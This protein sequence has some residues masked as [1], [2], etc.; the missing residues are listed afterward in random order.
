MKL[1]QHKK[2]EYVLLI[3]F[4]LFTIVGCA[5]SFHRYEYISLES[6][7]N[8]NVIKRTKIKLKDLFLNK[9]IPVQ[10]SLA[11]NLYTLNFEI[12]SNTYATSL[13]ISIKSNKMGNNFSI[14][15]QDFRKNP[16]ASYQKNSVEAK[17][18][19]VAWVECRKE[20]RKKEPSIIE[21]KVFD[22][23]GKLISEEVI[24]YK[25]KQNGFYYLIDGI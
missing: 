18:L 11:R 19:E 25:I 15:D 9:T 12:P 13:I 5:P 17:K 16:C 23:V 22:K 7:D 24:P 8:I 2:N 4:L 21:F 6:I 14:T 1:V 10:Y 20:R 3:L